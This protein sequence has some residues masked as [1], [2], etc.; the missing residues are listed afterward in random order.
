[1]IT[2]AFDTALDKMYV[3]LRRGGKTL[4]S[5][6][7]ETT[8]SRYHSA[9]LIPTIAAVLKEN[10]I[11]PAEVNLIATNIGPGSFTG[12]RACVTVARTMAQQIGCKAAG[13]SSLEILSK[14]NPTDKPTLVVLDARRGRYYV[15]KDGVIS[16]ESEKPDTEGYFVIT[17]DYPAVPLG[18]NALSAPASLGEILAQIAEQQGGSDWQKLKPL[19]L[20]PPSI[21]GK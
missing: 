4:S 3:V 14:L 9:E 1:M 21:H 15:W 6:I 20:Q 19:Y 8:E 13:V 10:N 16:L 2:L 7:V 11:K 5:K 12:I 17:D 18:E